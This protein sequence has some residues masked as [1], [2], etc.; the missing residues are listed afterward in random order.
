MARV[1]SCSWD[2][3]ATHCAGV[4]LVLRMLR[5]HLEAGLW[6]RLQG[7]PESEVADGWLFHLWGPIVVRLSED[8]CGGVVGVQSSRPCGLCVLFGF[9]FFCFH[10]N[11]GR[12][13]ALGLQ[14][15]SYS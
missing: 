9:P 3:L 8:L 12:Q 13:G 7:L 1:S 10:G 6:W 4:L 15:G 14:I 2:P 11:L 5:G